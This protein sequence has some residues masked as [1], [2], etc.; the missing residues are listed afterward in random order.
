MYEPIVTARS[1]HSFCAEHI[2]GYCTYAKCSSVY[3]YNVTCTAHPP[4]VCIWLITEALLHLLRGKEEWNS[5][6][7]NKQTSICNAN[8]STHPSSHDV[9]CDTNRTV[10]IRNTGFWILFAVCLFVCFSHFQ[11]PLHTVHYRQRQRHAPVL[12]RRR[13]MSLLVLDEMLPAGN[14]SVQRNGE[15][16]GNT[17]PL[18]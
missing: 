8:A 9:T 16:F 5:K 17:F 15:V 1:W 14:R 18:C 13:R 7:S 6:V 11:A 12:K 2:R 3:V 4:A 10:G